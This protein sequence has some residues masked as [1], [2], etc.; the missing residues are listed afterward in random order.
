MENIE[1][2]LVGIWYPDYLSQTNVPG[3]HFRFVDDNRTLGGHV[4]TFA[5]T[6][7]G[8]RSRP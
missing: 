3:F 2:T 7:V 4:F 5:L 6:A 8:C 1:G